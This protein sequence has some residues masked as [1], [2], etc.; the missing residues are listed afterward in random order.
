M[1]WILDAVGLEPRAGGAAPLLAAGR[2]L[3]GPGVLLVCRAA[4]LRY[5]LGAVLASALLTAF[6]TAL[7]DDHYTI[8]IFRQTNI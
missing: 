5:R 8:D 6:P 4:V 1:F 2:L 3:P 7:I